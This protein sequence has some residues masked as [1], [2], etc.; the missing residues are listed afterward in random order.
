MVLESEK[1]SQISD[2]TR[3]V[4]VRIVNI[5]QYFLQCRNMSKRQKVEPFYLKMEI[6]NL[7][8]IF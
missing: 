1:S 7:L 3:S 6:M 2:G 8:K 4:P 5:F